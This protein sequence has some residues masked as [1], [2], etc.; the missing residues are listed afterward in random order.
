[1]E[2]KVRFYLEESDNMGGFQFFYDINSGYGPIMYLFP[3]IIESNLENIF[4][5]I[6]EMNVQKSR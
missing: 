1:M 5:I 4:K 2:D 3:L 6:S